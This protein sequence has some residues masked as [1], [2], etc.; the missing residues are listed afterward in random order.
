MDI[1]QKLKEFLT[2]YGKVI[3]INF[4]SNECQFL[5]KLNTPISDMD[6][7]E[8]TIF[9]MKLQDNILSDYPK[10]N[11]FVNKDDYLEMILSK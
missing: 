6:L 10:R 3:Y 8:F 4:I 7:N 1:K 2:Q 5:I 11:K 9:L